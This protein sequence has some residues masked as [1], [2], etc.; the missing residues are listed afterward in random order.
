[1]KIYLND[2]SNM[3]KMAIMAI[4]GKN[5][6]KNLLLRNRWADFQE[7]WYVEFETTAHN[8]LFK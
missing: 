3:T 4:Y 7:T 5:L 2:A 1:M 8:S 6:S